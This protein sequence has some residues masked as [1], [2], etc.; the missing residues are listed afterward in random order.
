MKVNIEKINDNT[1]FKEICK[2]TSSFDSKSER[3]KKVWTQNVNEILQNLPKSRK[4]LI[5]NKEE[6]LPWEDQKGKYGTYILIYHVLELLEEDKRFAFNR[7]IEN[8]FSKNQ[9]ICTTSTKDKELWNLIGL[10]STQNFKR[11]KFINI[12]AFTDIEKGFIAISQSYKALANLVTKFE[13]VDHSYWENAANQSNLSNSSKIP[14]A[15]SYTLESNQNQSY[16]NN[17]PEIWKNPYVEKRKQSFSPVRLEKRRRDDHL[18]VISTDKAVLP[19]ISLD[20]VTSVHQGNKEMNRGPAEKNDVYWILKGTNFTSNPNFSY[21]YFQLYYYTPPDGLKLPE[22]IPIQVNPSHIRSTKFSS[23]S[24]LFQKGNYSVV[25]SYVHSQNPQSVLFS[26]SLSYEAYASNQDEFDFLFNEL[27]IENDNNYPTFDFDEFLYQSSFGGYQNDLSGSTKSDQGSNNQQQLNHHFYSLSNQFSSNNDMEDE[28]LDRLLDE[29]DE[30]GGDEDDGDSNRDNKINTGTSFPFSMKLTQ[31][32]YACTNSDIKLLRNLQQIKSPGVDFVDSFNRTPLYLATYY[33]HFDIIEQLFGNNIP[34]SLWPNP[35]ICDNDGVSPLHLACSHGNKKL[36][37][38][39]LA[40]GASINCTSANGVTPLYCAFARGFENLARYL[41]DTY[42]AREFPNNW[43]LRDSSFYLWLNSLP[44]FNHFVNNNNNKNNKNKEIK[45]EEKNKVFLNDKNFFFFKSE[46]IGNILNN[47]SGSFS[48]D[49]M[50]GE[51]NFGER[52]CKPYTNNIGQVFETHHGY[53][54]NLGH[55]IANHKFPNNIN[56]IQPNNTLNHNNTQPNNID[57]QKSLLTKK[58]ENQFKFQK[59]EEISRFTT[60]LGDPEHIRSNL[61]NNLTSFDLHLVIF[62][63]V[64]S[65]PKHSCIGLLVGQTHLLYCSAQSLCIHIDMRKFPNKRPLA[66]FPLSSSLLKDPHNQLLFSSA[67]SEWNLSISFDRASGKRFVS[68]LLLSLNLHLP[69]NLK[70]TTLS[71]F[72]NKIQS[73]DNVASLHLNKSDPPVATFN[74]LNELNSFKLDHVTNYAYH[75]L[76][77]DA[78]ERAFNFKALCE[79]IYGSYHVQ[80]KKTHFR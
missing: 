55:Y 28:Y 42:F 9:I 16:D 32:H 19:S 25:I 38:L 60:Y 65:N 36:V 30:D 71:A 33:G 52:E 8:R 79:R 64:E 37:D 23:K 34:S 41:V 31:W 59:T 77:L 10:K 26:N 51:Q 74:S 80:D 56:D 1:Q 18:P 14:L 20:N 13:P 21:L 47:L 22:M 63:T 5:L 43:V 4:Y 75:K 48:S 44:S 61:F 29:D 68:H 69:I 17:S 39:L 40:G 49:K 73:G 78:F 45:E 11:A 76:L 24:P 67:I 46:N 2:Q 70:E 53:P 62:P 57:T 72:L 58:I 12:R 54:P 27:N 3:K 50:G 66:L 7:Y 6:G 15:I 35:N